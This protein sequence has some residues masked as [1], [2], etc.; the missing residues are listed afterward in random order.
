MDIIRRRTP[1]HFTSTISDER[2][3]EL[4]YNHRPISEYVM[5]GSI[6]RVIANLWLKRDLS[7]EILEV[8]D[9]IVILLA[10]HGPAVS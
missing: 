1:T 10:D 4:E 7:P 6:T 3:E 8:L 2:G 5:S 9:T